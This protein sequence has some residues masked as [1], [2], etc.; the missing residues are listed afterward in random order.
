MEIQRSLFK[1]VL[2]FAF[3]AFSLSLFM[4]C[5]D[6][7]N[8]GLGL[9]GDET[10]QPI[11]TSLELTSFQPAPQMGIVGNFV[12]FLAGEVDDPTL[13]TTV[14]TGYVD[15]APNTV[16][17]TNYRNGTVEKVILRLE[18]SYMYGDTLQELTLAVHEVLEEFT[19]LVPNADSIPPVGPEL[20]QFSMI[21]TD[22]LLALELPASWVTHND[23]ALRTAD[24]AKDFHGFQLVPVSGNAV[25]GFHN[26][27]TQLTGLQ[28]IVGSDTLSLTANKSISQLTK[29]VNAGAQPDRVLFQNGTGPKVNLSFSLDTLQ[30][31]SLNRF[32]VRV[33]YDAS[34]LETPVNFFRPPVENLSL[35]GVLSD[36][37]SKVL[38]I[39]QSNEEG[40]YDFISEVLHDDMQQF[41][42]GVDP[43]ESYELRFADSPS[44][45]INSLVLHD[46]SSATATPVVILTYT[47][48]N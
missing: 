17:T 5:E 38:A 21:P 6:P 8:V 43:F 4:A 46:L 41:L 29:T 19:G 39:S 27:T 14:A 3:I 44:N 37:T 35:H 48:L 28:S 31:V 25:V 33:P 23:A 13:G 16:L 20:F 12:Q 26:A 1:T 22:T 32:V 36:T 18:P 24:F 47:E 15:V 9:V 40:Y 7:S 42:L 10:G 2:Q 30:N 34:A 11:T 45:S